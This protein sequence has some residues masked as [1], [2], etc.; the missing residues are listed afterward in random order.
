MNHKDWMDKEFVPTYRRMVDGLSGRATRSRAVRSADN[1][2]DGEVDLETAVPKP[3]YDSFIE[4][5][6]TLLSQKRDGNLPML[7]KADARLEAW[8]KEQTTWTPVTP[9]LVRNF[10]P[11]LLFGQ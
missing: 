2:L 7:L 5:Y 1:L 6:N 10:P 4:M 9:K 11:M 3:L 8:K